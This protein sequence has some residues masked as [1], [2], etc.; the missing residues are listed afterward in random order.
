MQLRSSSLKFGNQAHHTLATAAVTGIRAKRIIDAMP[1]NSPQR[2]LAITQLGHLNTQVG[3]PDPLELDKVPDT[4]DTLARLLQL[5]PLDVPTQVDR[6]AM[7]IKA[8]QSITAMP[9]GADRNTAM[10]QLQQYQQQVRT[11]DELGLQ[12]SLP[13]L[14][15]LIAPSTH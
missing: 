13:T 5:K 3:D 15:E 4:A 14:V 12:R 7:G 10:L 11:G 6:A 8:L 1:V 9:L 2:S